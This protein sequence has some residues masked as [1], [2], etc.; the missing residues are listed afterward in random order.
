MDDASFPAGDPAEAYALIEQAYCED[1]WADVLAM[2]NPLLSELGASRESPL[3]DLR[4]RLQILLAHTNL[5]GLGNPDAARDL[6]SAVLE[7]DGESSLLETARQGLRQCVP[8]TVAPEKVGLEKGPLQEGGSASVAMP[9][10]DAEAGAAPEVR[11]TAEP[12]SSPLSEP[13]IQAAPWA[14]AISSTAASPSLI[15]DVVDEPELIAVHQSDPLL[16]EEIELQI[17]PVAT[18]GRGGDEG[19]PSGDAEDA[20]LM[21]GLLK[22][23]I[24]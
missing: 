21:Q 5:Y 11:G 6:Y 16:S 19:T 7:D 14:T 23:V 17:Q 24:A 10:I 9:W 22:V 3:V 1:R 8:S 15:P 20:D 13:S 4:Q 12:D 18:R 2:G